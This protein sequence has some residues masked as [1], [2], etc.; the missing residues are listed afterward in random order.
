[1]HNSCEFTLFSS[2]EPVKWYIVLNFLL[3]FP[4]SLKKFHNKVMI[5]INWSNDSTESYKEKIP[6]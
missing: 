5:S 6:V 3:F 2:Q 1:M 4:N